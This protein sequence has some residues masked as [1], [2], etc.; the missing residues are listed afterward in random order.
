M[1]SKYMS[2][3]KRVLSFVVSLC[4]LSVIPYVCATTY[5]GLGSRFVDVP[6]TH[7]FFKTV[8]PFLR[9][10]VEYWHSDFIPPV[11]AVLKPKVQSIL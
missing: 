3:S 2:G 7:L 5:N 8:G 1:K 4:R 6:S 9:C 11:R 10:M